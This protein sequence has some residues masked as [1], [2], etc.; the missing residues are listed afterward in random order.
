MRVE[1]TSAPFW[2]GARPELRVH[3]ANVLVR[4]Q[5]TGRPLLL[6]HRGVCFSA[7]G[8]SADAA[9]WFQQAV[10]RLV[11]PGVGLR[12]E[13][14]LRILEGVAKDGA[15]CLAL[16]GCGRGTLRLDPASIGLPATA[17]KAKDLVTGAVLRGHPREGIA[18]EIRYP[19]QPL[20]VVIGPPEKIDALQGLYASAE[21]FRGL[22]RETGRRQSRGAS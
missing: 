18:V 16:W 21:V 13:G 7:I 3:G 6:E 15:A 11:S 19:N 1:G 8:F 2:T 14:K 10:G 4:E 20:V 9:C 17:S 22:P 5:G 12:A